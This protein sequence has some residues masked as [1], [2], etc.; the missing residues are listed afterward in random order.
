MNKKGALY[1]VLAYAMWGLLPLYWKLYESMSAPE[2]LA[3]RIIWSVVYVLIVV[4]AM[5]RLKELKQA[6]KDRKQFGLIALCAV[7]IT[8]NWMIY[9]YA[10]NSGNMI[11]ASL[12]YYINP[13]VCILLGVL[14]LRERMKKTQW[15]AIALAVVGVGIMTVSYGKFPWIA[16]TLAF[17]FG[18]Y[19]LV[20]K[21]VVVNST[22]GLAG[23]TIVVFP[24]ALGYA[25]ALHVQGADTVFSLPPLHLILL[26][27]AGVATA[28]PLLWFGKAAQ[29]LSLSTL[30][31]FQYLSPTITLLL[32]IF[33]Y[34]ESFTKID[35]IS[36]LFIWSAL[37]VFTL[38]H[39][40]K[41][42]IN[43]TSHSA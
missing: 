32:G 11:E 25:I 43:T 19:G 18:F 38:S 26:L 20:K 23:E 2:I 13:L 21:K 9:I 7:L 36:F 5:S 8:C 1:A 27:L 35:M 12:G 22:V 28:T 6:M 40:P 15:V 30:G 31:F 3:H 34:Q 42:R 14:F 10:V 24:F 16:I 4:A 33:L 37:V 17:S 41:K 39:L 29:T